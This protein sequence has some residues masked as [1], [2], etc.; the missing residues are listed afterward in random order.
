[1]EPLSLD[2]ADRLSAEFFGGN[3]AV[4][5]ISRDYTRDQIMA[6]FQANTGAM[7]S[8]VTNMIPEQIAYRLPGAPTGGDASGDE[9]HF[10]ISQIMTHMASGTAFHWWNLTRAIKAERPPMPKPPEGT[11]TTG[12]RRDVMGA[13]GWSGLSA[14]ELI[15]LLDETVNPYIEY[16]QKLPEESLT[17]GISSFGLFRDMAPHDWIFLVAIHSAMHLTQI[18]NMKAQLDFPA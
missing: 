9:H 14:P 18:R 10:D 2:L 7:K 8:E 15:A 5:R 4:S 13:G 16:V 17:A 12:K 6:F 1:M 3:P 11:T